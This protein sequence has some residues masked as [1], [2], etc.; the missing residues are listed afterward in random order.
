M[1]LTLFFGDQIFNFLNMP[2][3]QIYTYLK[4]RKT[5][6]FV[7]IFFFGNQISN[8]F[9]S[10]GAFEI[11]FKDQTIF[12]KLK[13]DRMPNVNEVLENIEKLRDKA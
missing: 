4:E 7:G 13:T 1:I 6:A 9:W 3:P 2:H 10:T 8:Y 11:Y 5:I 12:S